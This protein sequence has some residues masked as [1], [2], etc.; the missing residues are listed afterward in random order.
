V[1]K[2]IGG[3]AYPLR[4]DVADQDSVDSMFN[5]LPK[6]LH[7][8]S[9]LVNNAGHDIGGRRRFDE[10]QMTNWQSIIET[11]VLGLIRMTHK[12]IA[13]MIARDRGHIVNFGSIAGTR[14]YA[15][16]TIYAG[17]KFAVHGFSE[18]L[19]LDFRNTGIRVTEIQP[20]MV[21]TD[22]AANRL[23]GDAASAK[24]YY[25]EF[26]C[27]WCPPTWRGRW[28]LPYSSRHTSSSRN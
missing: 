5:R 22:F 24:A 13:G 7:A 26:G 14:G 12:V 20:G 8:I 10:G 9:I 18:S 28:C 23:R 6:E 17:S 19:R 2:R 25:D 15:G 21:R 11:N 4:L 27:A 3:G 1:V 16:G